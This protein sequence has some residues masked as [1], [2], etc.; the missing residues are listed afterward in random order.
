MNI[1]GYTVSPGTEFELRRAAKAERDEERERQAR[2]GGWQARAWTVAY[3]VHRAN[4]A[5]L[6]QI[7]LDAQ[8]EQMALERAGGGRETPGAR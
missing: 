5:M 8:R 2:E 7:E 3:D 4:Q 6:T 1:G